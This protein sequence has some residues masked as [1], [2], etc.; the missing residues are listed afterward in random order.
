MK[1]VLVSVSAIATLLAMACN[2]PSPPKEAPRD[3]RADASAPVAS[4]SAPP[5]T[6]A[7][8]GACTTDADCRTWSTY[9]KESP[10][11]CRVLS[12]SESNPQC[13]SGP[14]TCV[15]DPCM[16]KKAACQEG[17]CALV[18]ADTK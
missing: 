15:V 13:T 3:A 16:R 10:C 18:I 17:H 7:T 14:V 6:A 11:G 2:N 9:C 1:R 5:T 4:S 8:P 12:K